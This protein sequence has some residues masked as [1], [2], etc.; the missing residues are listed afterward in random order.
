MSAIEVL[1]V[2]D[3]QGIGS[4]TRE[5][6]ERVGTEMTVV[7]EDGGKPALDRL[8]ETAFD[9]IVSDYDMPGMDGL[10]F[11]E[12]VRDREPK[13]PFIL[14][15]G[16]G[17]EDIASEAISAG[18]TDYLQKGVGTGQYELLANRIENAVSQYRAEK[19]AEQHAR[20]NEVVRRTS[21][22]VIQETEPRLVIQ[23][24]CECI[25]ESDEYA[26]S[27]FVEPDPETGEMNP[28]CWAGEDGFLDIIQQVGV[29]M[30]EA[31]TGQ[32]PGGR[33]ARSGEVQILRDFDEDPAFEPWRDGAEAEGLR[34]L[35]AVPL[36][37]EDSMVGVLGIFATRKGAFDETERQLLG[38]LGTTI[39]F[40]VTVARERT[41]EE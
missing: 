8:S 2:D 33:A 11:L 3:D 9:C 23:A 12:A 41:G 20:I 25:A 14:F 37:H 30:D 26:F 16:K 31:P 24:A 18:V 40:A 6:L 36:A 27:V 29:R 35:A 10:E 19:R 1:H 5:Y 34:S 4:L 28:T 17:S 32:G 21:Q 13:L 38:G 15:T 39:A 7:T 22:A